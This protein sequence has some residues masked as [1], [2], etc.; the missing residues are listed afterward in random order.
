M[1][2]VVRDKDSG[3]PLAGVRI[4]CDKTAEFPVHGFNGIEATTDDQGRYRLGGLP[5][6]HGNHVIAIPSRGQPYLAAGLE[7]PDT[8]GLDPVSLDIGL[9]R[10]IVIEGRVTD[11]QTGSPLKAFVS[12]NAYKDNPHFRAPGFQ[13]ARVWGQYQTEPDGSFR[14]VGLPGRGLIAAMCIGGGK[15]YLQ[16]IGLPSVVSMGDILP[17]VP[18]GM[19]G[20][21]NV[22]SEVDLP[23][24]ATVFRRDLALESGV[25]RTVRVVDPDGQPLAGARIRVHPFSGQ[26]EPARTAPSLSSNLCGLTRLDCWSHFMKERSSPAGSKFAGRNR[27][28]VS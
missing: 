11:K 9:K 15:Q 5:K 23:R 14:V 24:D 20:H 4:A 6:G 22:L 28:S 26:L 25:T 18:D 1:V 3:Q 19:L 27:E 8:P 7:I 16:G 13:E 21:F 2:G 12:Y 10:G 17:V